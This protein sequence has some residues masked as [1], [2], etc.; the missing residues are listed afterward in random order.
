MRES[1]GCSALRSTSTH[2][3]SVQP[4]NNPLPNESTSPSLAVPGIDDCSCGIAAILESRSIGIWS[5]RSEGAAQD[6][7]SVQGRL[8]LTPSTLPAR[9]SKSLDQLGP[10]IPPVQPRT[11]PKTLPRS[12]STQLFPRQ[13]GGRNVTPPATVPSRG[14]QRSAAPSSSTLFPPSGQQACSA[15]NP[16]LGSTP[17][18]PLPRAKSTQMLVL[19][20]QQ[21]ADPQTSITS[22]L[23]AMFPELPPG[24]ELPGY[25]SSSKSCEQTLTVPTCLPTM[26][27]GQMTDC[28]SENKASDVGEDMSEYPLSSI[29]FLGRKGTRDLVGFMCAG[30][31]FIAEI[32]GCW[33]SGW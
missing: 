33:T 9:H 2:A 5:P 16:S 25:R 3:G 15:P 20:R 31:S 13:R 12:V 30:I 28:W 29:A 32:K 8:T 19:N 6:I 21:Q 10:E 27:H 1:L 17:V 24:G 11:S 22:L 26:E 14:R 23:A 18:V 7:G 4:L